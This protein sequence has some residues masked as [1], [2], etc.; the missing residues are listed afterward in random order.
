MAGLR[1][2]LTAGVPW[3]MR[4]GCSM[5]TRFRGGEVIERLSGNQARGSRAPPGVHSGYMGRMEGTP[6]AGGRAPSWRERLADQRERDADQRDALSDQRE[7]D[8]DQR[9]ALSDQR[10]RLTGERE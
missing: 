6:N 4:P 3:G 1:V 10:E 5:S 8:A 9:D 7:R 2:L